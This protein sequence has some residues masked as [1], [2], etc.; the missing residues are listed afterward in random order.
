MIDITLLNFNVFALFCYFI[1]YSFMGWCL[2]TV[3]TT[4]RKKE[5]VNRGFLHGPFCPIYGF[6]ILSIIVLLKPIENN[7]IFLL[8]GSIFLTS[9]IE[10][11][12]GYILET[13]FDSTWWDYS[14]EPY[15]LHGRIC[16]KF[17]I[18]WGFISILILKVIHPYIKYIVNLIPP[19]PGV[20]LFYITL[21]YFILDFIITII[22]ILKLKSLLTQLITA[23]SEL[24]DKFLDF[25]LNLGNTKSIPELRIKLDQL[26]DLAETKM[27]RKKFNIENI[28]KE[29]KI[30][31]DSLFIKKYP[32]Y[33]RIIKA[34]PDLK[35]KALDA[36]FKD[37][38]QIIHKDKK[39]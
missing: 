35:F 36:I 28:I 34:F 24:T 29:V 22:T 18:I 4:I 20:F 7:Y 2:E 17:S 8:L 30:K 19:N 38:K 23:Y 10:Y 26:I 11:I 16:L 3:Y 6:A 39:G 14:D 1:V 37:V 21:V 32:N 12:T 31:Y 9:L 27:S 25:K 15:N 13:T 5:F 33:S